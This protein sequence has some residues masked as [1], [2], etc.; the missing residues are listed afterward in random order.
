MNYKSLN[1][2]HYDG[3][4]FSKFTTSIGDRETNHLNLPG[5]TKTEGQGII[6]EKTYR[7]SH[8][9]EFS[10][11]GGQWSDI[12]WLHVGDLHRERFLF[13]QNGTFKV[14]V[15]GLLNV[16]TIATDNASSCS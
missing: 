2:H 8:T 10:G 11:H 13:S 4:I 7:F 9:R 14:T 3:F 1:N 6:I 15:A 12:A 5:L 16:V